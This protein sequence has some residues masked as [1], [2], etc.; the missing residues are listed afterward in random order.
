MLKKYLNRL[1]KSARGETFNPLIWPSLIATFVYGLG[2]T[3]FSW[4]PSVGHSSLWAALTGIHAFLPFIWGAAAL[5]VVIVGF[6][7]LLFNI[8]PAGKVSGIAGF[9]V[10]LFAGWAW[11]LTGGGFVVFAVALPNMWFW[12]WQYLSLSKFAREDTEDVITMRDYDEGEYDDELNPKDSKIDREENR[13]M[14]RQS[15]GSYD[16]PDDGTDT[17]RPL[18]TN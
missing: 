7:F 1:T 9:M 5:C 13:G 15:S 3:A 18:D 6:T 4:V 16:N 12:I 2:F 8:P 17:S 11:W 10:W 14:D